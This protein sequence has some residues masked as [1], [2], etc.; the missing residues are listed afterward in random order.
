MPSTKKHLM[1]KRPLRF[2][3]KPQFTFQMKLVLLGWGKNGAG[4]RKEND[5]RPL[6]EVR[7]RN[8]A[9]CALQKGKPP[10]QEKVTKAYV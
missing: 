5:R 7:R 4:Y 10:C 1:K 6:E 2:T 8:A 9:H 3:V